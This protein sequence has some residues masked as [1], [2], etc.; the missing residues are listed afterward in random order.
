MAVQK[1][2]RL[3]GTRI[4][5]GNDFVPFSSVK[6]GGDVAQALKLANKALADDLR[7]FDIL[8]AGVRFDDVAKEGHPV[9]RNGVLSVSRER[10][11]EK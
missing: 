6:N 4:V 8:R 11:R 2:A 3:T 9:F 1:K 10:E 7:A 5:E